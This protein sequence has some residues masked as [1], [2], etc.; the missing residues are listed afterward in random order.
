LRTV[1]KGDR[2]V[3]GPTAFSVPLARRTDLIS[4]SNGT[5]LD[6]PRAEGGNG[7]PGQFPQMLLEGC[8]FEA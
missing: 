3:A 7:S 1:G 4:R 5:E 2:G 6:Y 8:P